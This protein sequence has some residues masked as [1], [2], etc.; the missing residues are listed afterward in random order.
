LARD[1]AEAG[2]QPDV[3]SVN[4]YDRASEGA[5]FAIDRRAQLAGGCG[6]LKIVTFFRIG[7]TVVMTS[8][9]CWNRTP[10]QPMGLAQRLSALLGWWR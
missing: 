3:V 6:L 1:L 7:A 9:E 4:A 10:F 8:Q 5:T 2:E